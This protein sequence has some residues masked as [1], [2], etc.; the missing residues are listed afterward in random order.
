MKDLKTYC[1]YCH[2]NKTNG[3]KYIGITGQE[4]DKRWRQGKGYGK[5]SAIFKAFQRYGWDGFYHDVLEEGLSCEQAC[6]EEIRY[7]KELNTLVPNGY[8][9]APGGNASEYFDESTRKKLSEITIARYKTPEWK[10]RLSI[11]NSGEKNPRYGKHCSEETKKKIR[12]KHL[13]TKHSE[14]ARIKM[15]QNHADF[16][17]ANNSNARAIKQYTW[18]CKFVAEY[19]CIINAMKAVPN[20]DI[21]SCLRKR[22]KQAGGYIWRYSDDV[23]PTEPYKKREKHPQKYIKKTELLDNR[24]S[25]KKCR[26]A[27]TQRQPTKVGQYDL[28][29]NLIAIY[30]SARE[31]GRTLNI[32][33]SGIINCCTGK[34]R[35]SK[36]FVFQYLDKEVY[37]SGRADCQRNRRET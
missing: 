31:A 4:L 8:N 5:T 13:G 27:S 37:K 24:I 15:S 23:P 32:T 17:G 19:D 26:K 34:Q 29:G 9:V 6:K 11:Q 21:S 7:I 35:Y 22:T 18:D 16:T 12:E 20:C 10:K 30:N 1:V 36:G 14:K 25:W 28:D 2:T 33:P 3:K